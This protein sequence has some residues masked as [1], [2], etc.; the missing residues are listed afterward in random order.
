MKQTLIPTQL[1]VGPEDLLIEKTENLLRQNFCRKEKDSDCFCPDC[2]KIKNNQ[3]EFIVWINPEKDYT[4]KDIQIIFEK[5]NFALD[6]NQKFFF[7]LQKAH[8]LNLTSA[9]KLLKIL[10]EPPSGYNFIL[11]TNN[12]NTILPTMYSR[13]HVTNFQNKNS[14]FI[15]SHPLLSFFYNKKINNPLEFEA[16]LKKHYL[17]DSQSIE[18]A[19]N[20]ISFFAEKIVAHY[21]TDNKKTPEIKYFED[22]LQYLKEKIK[23]PPQSG[24]SKLFWKNVYIS[25]PSN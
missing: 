10:E 11:L 5:T 3:H 4:I 18:L 24:S 19:N 14:K 25:F 9:N 21:S 7:I 17:S 23:K 1:F 22:V 16:E 13:C 2:R 20:M 6:E 15:D 8:T 12:A